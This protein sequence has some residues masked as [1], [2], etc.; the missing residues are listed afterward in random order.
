MKFTRALCVTASLISAFCHAG[1]VYYVDPGE[2]GDDTADGSAEH[3][4]KTLVGVMALV[5][6]DNGDIVYAAPGRYDNESV[7][8]DG[9]N[10]RVSIPAGTKLISTGT[11]ENT[12]LVGEADT[13]ADA[14][15]GCGP[16]A[17][18][19]GY[20][21]A[22]AEIH[23]FTI[24]G[25][26]DTQTSK[27][28]EV[29]PGG[30]LGEN[31]STC[32][33]YN[34]IY[35]NLVTQCRAAALE[36]VTSI[37]CYFGRNTAGEGNGDSFQIQNA[38]NCVFG[39]TTG[40][41]GYY[42]CNFYNCTFLHRTAR[43]QCKIYNSLILAKDGNGGNNYYNCFYPE[44]DATAVTNGTCRQIAKAD[45]PY[46]PLTY[47]PYPT[48]AVIDA[49]D[50]S[51]VKPSTDIPYADY[52]GGSRILNGTVDIGAVEARAW[53]VVSDADGLDFTG[54]DGAVTVIPDG[55][56]NVTIRRNYK[57]ALKVKGIRINGG[58]LFEFEGEIEDRVWEGRFAGGENVQIDVVYVD[59][60]DWYVDANH[61]DD[62]NDGYTPYRARRTLKA[63][64]A[65]THLKAGEIVHAAAGVYDE[66]EMWDSG[67]ADEFGGSNRVIVATGVGLVATNAAVTFI[68]GRPHKDEDPKAYG[69]RAVRCVFLNEGSWI[70]NFT[71]TNG[72]TCG[73][74]GGDWTG[75]GGGIC[76]PGDGAAVG[77]LV[78]GCG[79]I[80]S[81]RL[82]YG[83]TM[84]RCRFRDT[85]GYSNNQ[86]EDCQALISCMAE[87]E[88]VGEAG[89]FINSYANILRGSKAYNSFVYYDLGNSEYFNS[90]IY[91]TLNA[92]SVKKDEA[93][94]E[95]CRS[96]PALDDNGRLSRSDALHCDAGSLALYDELFPERWMRFKDKD[97]SGGQRVYNE[98][99]D[100]GPLEADWRGVY[101]AALSAKRTLVA[102]AGPGV[103]AG[104]GSL[105]L[106]PGD[107]LVLRLD[108]KGYNGEAS[109]SVV[110]D[111][112]VIVTCAGAVASKNGDIYTFNAGPGTVEVVISVAQAAVVSDV[113]L[114]VGG[115]SIRLR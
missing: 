3:P 75:F 94:V 69:I 2:K 65:L 39:P 76:S 73:K 100:I 41:H 46:D 88:L 62:A 44:L 112:E 115:L 25:G 59:K 83:G 93:T 47:A 82:V 58:E 10:Y 28:S 57:T 55:G 24:T 49:G 1:N 107:K 19:C 85:V 92:S 8:V 15:D 78:V 60:N 40:Y 27:S 111:G 99:I 56:L 101:T 102:E 64:M 63:A 110:S 4:R 31:K 16:S 52:L 80:S 79:S 81:G 97:L 26:R 51:Y 7:S 113:R 54:L 42:Q 50:N 106:L 32:R 37:G 34:C 109:V 22:G 114:P 70:E 17:V 48:S 103:T 84:I 105:N 61:G 12:F 71:V 30:L 38:Y 13:T 36:K 98:K 5:K 72:F 14:V 96:Y 29:R 66:G 23:G 45:A 9:I 68:K 43:A 33:A 67:S 91:H 11:R 20:L 35:S 21:A 104:T 6:S 87:E 53:A 18:R 90:R 108:T 77:C 89:A 86:I 95:N 74:Y